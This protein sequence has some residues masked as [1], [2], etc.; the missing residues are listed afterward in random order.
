ML[1]IYDIKDEPTPGPLILEDLDAMWVTPWSMHAAE[2][3]ADRM[4]AGLIILSPG[5]HIKC[6]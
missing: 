5:D 4:L 1:I 6:E 2:P 3:G